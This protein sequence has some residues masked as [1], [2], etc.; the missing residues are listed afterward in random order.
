[1][2]ATDFGAFPP[3]FVGTW[4]INAPGCET[5]SNGGYKT[6]E[7]AIAAGVVEY[8]G[9]PFEIGLGAEVN[10][11]PPDGW[12]V[13]EWLGMSAAGEVGDVADDYLGDVLVSEIDEL[14]ES[15]RRVVGE[16]LTRH[17]LWPAFGSIVN[18]ER[19][20][21]TELRAA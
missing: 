17:S 11:S 21:P 5:W 18:V 9:E 8:R 7:D 4:H 16:W 10:F 14:T 12:R 2:K 20:D 3:T 1:M 15:L 19:I 13:A 6:R